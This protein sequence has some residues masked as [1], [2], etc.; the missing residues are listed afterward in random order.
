MTRLCKF[1]VYVEYILNAE[2]QM[3]LYITIF[4]IPYV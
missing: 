2:L 4:T 1:H 3:F